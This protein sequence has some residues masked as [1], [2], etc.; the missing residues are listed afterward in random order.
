VR[1]I[2]GNQPLGRQRRW[3]ITSHHREEVVEDGKWMELAQDDDD[4][5][6]SSGSVTNVKFKQNRSL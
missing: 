2:F 6:G 4:N 5:D 3:K 1:N